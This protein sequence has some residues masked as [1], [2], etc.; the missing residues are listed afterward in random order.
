MKKI[1]VPL[2]VFALVLVLSSGTVAELRMD[3]FTIDAGLSQPTGETGDMW[4]AGFNVGVGFYTPYSETLDWGLRAA[5]SRWTPNSK[6]LLG[7][8]SDDLRVEQSTGSNRIGSLSAMLRYRPE[9]LKV[10][11][12]DC[13]AGLYYLRRQDVAVKG[14]VE[15][16]SPGNSGVVIYE[17]YSPEASD[18]TAGV[19]IGFSFK[20]FGQLKPGIR[21]HYVFS[22]GDPIQFAE[23]GITFLAR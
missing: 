7:L 14:S 1:F 10:V 6:K 2:T 3:D 15:Y 11:T 12:L 5:Y 19:N 9:Q 23:I 20:L 8:D 4:S 13:G 18:L 22:S 17:A 16:G 21:Y